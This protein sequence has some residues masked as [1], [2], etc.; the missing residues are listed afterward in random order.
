MPIS[1]VSPM[2]EHTIVR[3][4]GSEKIRQHL[5]NLGFIVGEPII[6]INRVQESVIVKLKGVSLAITEDLAKKIYV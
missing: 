1:L 5:Q 4:G 2:E 6:V 3:I